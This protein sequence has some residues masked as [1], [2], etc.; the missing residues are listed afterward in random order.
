M[1]YVEVTP[2]GVAGKAVE[3]VLASFDG[4]LR[5]SHQP[6]A[7]IRVVIDLTDESLRL[8][9]G[10]FEIAHWAL[11]E[12]RVSARPDGFH[13]REAGEEI[14]LTIRQDAEFAVMLDLRSVPVDLARRM[15][16]HRNGRPSSVAI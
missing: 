15:A 13:I 12:V 11:D 4:S 3:V 5:M 10:E 6:D 9:S 14:I 16:V 2:G 8:T 7:P 1:G